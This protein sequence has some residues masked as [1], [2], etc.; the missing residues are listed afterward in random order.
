M[1]DTDTRHV[2]RSETT[3]IDTLDK[4]AV[5][6]LGRPLNATERSLLKVYLRGGYRDRWELS[7]GAPHPE[8]LS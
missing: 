8:V 7:C 5:A 4:Q 2:Q 1:P 6:Y 3:D